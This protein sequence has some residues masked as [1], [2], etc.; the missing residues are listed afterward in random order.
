MIASPWD[1]ETDTMT[2]L[3]PRPLVNQMLHHAQQQPEQEVC[4]L[5]GSRAGVPVQFYHVANVATA[6]QRRMRERGEGLYAIFHSHPHSP[7][8]PSAIDLVQAA[9]PEAIYIIASLE[10][11]G[12]LEMRGYHLRD[13]V[14]RE[15]MLELSGC[16]S[17]PRVCTHPS[18]SAL[19]TPAGGRQSRRPPRAAATTASSLRAVPV[20][21]CN[22]PPGET[23]RVTARPAPRHRENRPRRNR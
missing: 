14:A 20:P 17:Y 6:P 8:S 15:V 4:G 9:Y 22:S 7:P 13:G 2:A 16:T 12:V 19:P 21:G 5:I 11:K 18:A 23:H 1:D 10:T 3:L